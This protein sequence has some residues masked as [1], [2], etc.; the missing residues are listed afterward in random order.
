LF[1]GGDSNLYRYAGT[2]PINHF[3]PEGLQAIPFPAVDPTSA[4]A[5]AAAA[6]ILW[7]ASNPECRNGVSFTARAVADYAV[8]A[9]RVLMTVD[10]ERGDQCYRRALNNYRACQRNWPRPHDPVWPE[11]N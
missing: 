5:A 6:A 10:F 1:E 3:D 11:C 9:G 8:C 7:C 4:A 2:D